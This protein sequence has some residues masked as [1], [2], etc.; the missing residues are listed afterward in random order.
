MIGPLATPALRPLDFQPVI[1]QDEQMWLLRDPL[2]LTDFQIIFPAPLASMLQFIDGTRTPDQICTAF[3]HFVGTAVDPALVTH[4]LNTL[5]EA[6]LLDNE[7]AGE[8][9]TRQLAAFRAQPMRPPALADLS[10]PAE[11]QALS[12]QFAQY[13]RGDDR[14]TWPAWHGRGIISPHIDYQRGGAV[15]AR[16]WQ[17]SAAALRDAD[18][19]IIFGTDHNGGPG[20]VTLTHL[21]FATPYGVLP[22]DSELVDRLATA[23]GPEA[24]FRDELHHRDEHAI[25]L[26]AVWLHHVYHTAGVA[27]RPMVPLLIGSF[28]Q[29]VQDGGHPAEDAQI[30][31]VIET[32]HNATAGKKVVAVASV[33]LAHVGPNFGDGYVMDAR[34]RERLRESDARL[35]QAAVCGDADDWYRQIAAVGDRNR[36]CG[37]SPVYYLLRFLGPTS[38]HILAYDQCPADAQDQSLVSICGLLL[39]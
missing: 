19:V 35:M 34:R 38:G 20:T 26:S 5:D 31:A 17:R 30:T 11:P 6:C 2:R 7:R 13:G 29:F 3:S 37:F 14:S 33:D 4:T 36:I 9:Q 28:M 8:A 24:A 1:Y 32:L 27:P 23:V 39:D 18:L 22:A 25:E 10:Y 21:P 15:Y 12:A 16:V